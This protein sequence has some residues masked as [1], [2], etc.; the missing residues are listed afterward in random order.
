VTQPLAV[1]ANPSGG[2]TRPAQEAGAQPPRTGTQKLQLEYWRA[3]FRYMRERPGP[4]APAVPMPQYRLSFYPFSRTGFQLVA[5]AGMRDKWIG[6]E[7]LLL[8]AEAASRFRALSDERA[9]IE[10]ELG[11]RLEWQERPNQKRSA[12][13]LRAQRADPNNRHAWRAQHIW[14]CE[15]LEAFHRVFAP[16]IEKLAAPAR[17]PDKKAAQEGEATPA[18][19]ITEEV[20]RP[21]LSPWLVPLSLVSIAT[22]T[23]NFVWT[24]IPWID[25]K[26]LLIITLAGGIGAALSFIFKNFGPPP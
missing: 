17:A 26:E 24:V 13:M 8:G 7:L 1:E 20:G 5:Y 18:R 23:V 9:E 15:R 21:I 22:G 25:P 16:R 11:E 3:F 14:L 19:V 4:V 12:V 2:D 10:R 6:V